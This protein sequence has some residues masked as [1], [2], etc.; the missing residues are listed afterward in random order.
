MSFIASIFGAPVMVP[1]VNVAAKRSNISLPSSMCASTSETI[2][3]TCEYFSTR[4]ISV[5]FTVPVCATRPTSLRPRSMSM[6]CS[7]HS[8]GSFSISSSSSL[9]RWASLPRFRVPAIGRSSISPSV[10]LTITSGLEP[11][12]EKSS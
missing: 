3:I 11:Q 8:F 5:T 7:A 10:S 6:R 9:S 1:A 2:C 4:I 12:I